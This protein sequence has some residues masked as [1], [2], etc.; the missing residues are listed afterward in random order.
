MADDD[1]LGTTDIELAIKRATE[2]SPRLAQARE[3]LQGLIDTDKD[4]GFRALADAIRRMMH[5]K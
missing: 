5:Q 1:E 2:Q 4:A 3:K